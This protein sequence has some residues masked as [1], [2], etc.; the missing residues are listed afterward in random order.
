[1]FAVIDFRL[2]NNLKYIFENNKMANQ[3]ASLQNYNSELIKML[4]TIKESREE[5]QAEIEIEE[6]EKRQIEEQMRAFTIRMQELQDSL[7][8]KYQTRNDF[9][10]TIGETENAFMKILESSQTLLHV[11]KKEGQSLSKKKAQT[12]GQSATA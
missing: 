11:L 4:E 3:G 9:D 8:K 10:K 1:M 5:V 7:Q 12:L 2:P 6:N